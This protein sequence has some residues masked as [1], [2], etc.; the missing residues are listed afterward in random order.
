MKTINIKTILVIA[1][2]TIFTTACTDLYSDEDNLIEDPI[3][4]TQA[5]G[6]NGNHQCNGK[7]C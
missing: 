2:L 1:F 7:N 3:E 4:N 6:D 5:T